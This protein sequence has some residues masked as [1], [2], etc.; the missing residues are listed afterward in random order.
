MKKTDRIDEL[1]GYQNRQYASREQKAELLCRNKEFLSDLAKMQTFY[2]LVRRGR[3]FNKYLKELQ[4]ETPEGT[5]IQIDEAGARFLE[6][7]LADLGL[8]QPPAWQWFYRKWDIVPHWPGE[9]S[10]LARFIQAG[11]SL[12]MRIS[13]GGQRYSYIHREMT[14]DLE[15]DRSEPF[16]MPDLAIGVDPWTTREDISRL[17]RILPEQIE[18]VFGFVTETGGFFARDLCWYDLNEEM[19]LTPVQIAKLWA[20]KRPGDLLKMMRK[21]KSGREG[22][23]VHK[24]KAAFIADELPYAVREAID[25]LQDAVNYLSVTPHFGE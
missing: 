21:H 1:L 15:E 3:G 20:R 23:K 17:C 25:R 16:P 18:R 12:Y 14:C 24:E 11:P 19:G 9:K 5:P 8:T 10:K 4:A 22:R 7:N 6:K 13:E 2:A